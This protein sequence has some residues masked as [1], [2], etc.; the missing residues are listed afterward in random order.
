[1]RC[2]LG[3]CTALFAS[4]LAA[5]TVGEPP[6]VEVPDL[7][8]H[9]DQSVQPWTSLDVQDSPDK[10][11]FAVVTDRTGGLRQ[12]VFPIGVE[13]LNLVQPAFVMSV[14]D[15]IE[16]YTT[17][18]ETI[19]QEWDEFEGFTAKLDAPFFYV[20][21]NHDMMNA[22][23]ADAWETRFGAS[24]Y[25]FRYKDVLFVVLN[26]EI[27]DFDEDAPHLTG[28]P[29]NLAWR[30]S[31][32]AL[33]ARADQLA[34]VEDVLAE[35]ADVRWT[36]MFVHKPFWRDGWEYPPRKP[37]GSWSDFDLS[38]YPVDGPWP[39][40]TDTPAGWSKVL[41]MLADRDFTAFAGHLHAYEYTNASDGAHTHDL[42]ALATTGGVSNLRG[43]TYGEFDH[44]V[45]VTMTENGPVIANLLL[46]GVL[47]KAIE[48]PDASPWFLAE[49]AQ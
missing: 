32:A 3:F 25:H 38:D 43:V 34:Y 18:E 33:K 42:I 45:W 19:A 12:G 40:I 31:E 27:M 2:G 1:M 11:H 16:G 10:F 4:I 48:T 17:N 24:Y 21:G 8:T 46:D 37:G 7:A 28:G 26:S 39:T 44:V 14:G 49:D 15:L 30:Q 36:F 29:G 5:C 23:M 41:D 47:G 22:Q 35:N 13:K 20:A 6:M 9:H